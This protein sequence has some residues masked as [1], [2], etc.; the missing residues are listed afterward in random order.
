MCCTKLFGTWATK[1]SQKAEAGNKVQIQR[2]V[3]QQS[4]DELNWG[5]HKIQQHENR[6]DQPAK[7]HRMRSRQRQQTGDDRRWERGLYTR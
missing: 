7:I 4:L 3:Q 2:Q 5:K 1:L 6:Q